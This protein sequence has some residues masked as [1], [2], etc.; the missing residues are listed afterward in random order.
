M[1]VCMHVCMYVC[2]HVFMYVC[3]HT[4]VCMHVCMYV[5]MH[6]YVCIYVCMYVCMH[7]CM[8]VCMHAYVCMYVCM[9]ACGVSMY[10]CILTQVCIPRRVGLVVSVSA[11]HAVCHWFMSRQGHIEYHHKNGTNHLPALAVQFGNAARLS[12]CRG[13]VLNFLWGHALKIHPGINCKSRL[14]YPG[15]RYLY[16]AMLKKT[17]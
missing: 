7:V 15:P 13:S 12:K 14:W 16:T 6:A 17:L 2:M 3:M 4:Y 9:Y 1:Y 8:C 11:C 10:A 5:C